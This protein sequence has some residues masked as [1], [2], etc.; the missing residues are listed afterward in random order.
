MSEREHGA[1]IRGMVMKAAHAGYVEEDEGGGVESGVLWRAPLASVDSLSRQ[2]KE[3]WESFNVNLA[4]AGDGRG[5]GGAGRGMGGWT[6]L[7]PEY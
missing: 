3:T 2:L 5:G 7:L 1:R 6:P 4:V